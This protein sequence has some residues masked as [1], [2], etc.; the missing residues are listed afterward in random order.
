MTDLRNISSK[1]DLARFCDA[2]YASYADLERDV[3][4]VDASFRYREFSIPKK[5]GS[6]RP[7]SAPRRKLKKIQ[8]AIASGLNDV[9]RPPAA[10]H[11]FVR[12][13]SIVS[14]AK[15]HIG[16]R[17]V[18]TVDLEDFFHSIRFERI[19][20]LFRAR[21]FNYTASLAEAM[22]R[23]CCHEG[24][25]PMG[26]PTSPILSNMICRT[27]DQNLTTLAT[28]G[29][30]RYSRYADD[31]T[32]SFDCA[33]EAMPAGIASVQNGEVVLGPELLDIIERKG[34]R[35]NSRKVR[36]AFSHQRQE[37][38]GLSVNTRV[39]VPRRFL[40]R[41]E[42][43]LHAWDKYLLEGAQQH[44]EMRL[45]SVHWASQNTKSFPHVLHGRLAHLHAVRGLED[46]CYARLA[47]HF[48]ELAT[49]DDVDL[50]L[51][52]PP[53]SRLRILYQEMVQLDSGRSDAY[54][55][56]GAVAALIAELWP[57]RLMYRGSEVVI[58]DGRKRIDIVYANQA[59]EGF[60]LWAARFHGAQHILVECKNYS[61]DP[62]NPEIDQLA[63][64]FTPQRSEFGFM[65][66]R[67]VEDRELLQARAKDIAV[68][69]RGYILVFD[70]ADFGALVELAESD[71]TAGMDG[72][73]RSRFERLVM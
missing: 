10:V 51:P 58:N 63:M 73:L 14:N 47:L 66:C 67:S 44:F 72:F 9:Y 11:G 41:T 27:M 15:M 60:L 42:A 4:S 43:M 54:A 55:Y 17:V 46:S 61:G 34:F 69:G 22:A 33:P 49:R 50:A 12:D 16:R 1:D 32:F 57:G 40:R 31:L 25:L 38:T 24:H 3:Y 70:D 23:L 53:P 71:D 39:N 21:P 64:R 35:V 65:A 7:I 26:A 56:Q 28:R 59:D 62:G 48:N 36:V 37:V 20:G 8:R 45:D 5:D 68:S 13:Q 52:V 29:R 19:R 2:R 18:L 6:T 30:A